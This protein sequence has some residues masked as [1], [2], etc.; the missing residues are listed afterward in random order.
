[1]RFFSSGLPDS[2][3][4]ADELLA[5]LNTAGLNCL[6]MLRYFCFSELAAA[7][8]GGRDHHHF[9]R[10]V[11]HFV[12]RGGANNLILRYSLSLESIVRLLRDFCADFCRRSPQ[13]PPTVMEDRAAHNRYR[14]VLATVDNGGGAPPPMQPAAPGR[15]AAPLAV[16]VAVSYSTGFAAS[17]SAFPADISPPLPAFG[18]KRGPQTPPTLVAGPSS[19]VAPL[20]PARP[21]EVAAPRFKFEMDDPKLD[22]L[23][24]HPL[25][26]C[27][28]GKYH[29]GLLGPKKICLLIVEQIGK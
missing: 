9:H 5:I 18:R 26:N 17:S 15:P 19:A 12:N 21:Q 13:F 1:L 28:V 24:N 25:N 11:Q 20:P 6:E 29:T 2:V 27:K 3:G 14:Q 4:C 7:A 16:A 8:I 23:H 22:T 10:I